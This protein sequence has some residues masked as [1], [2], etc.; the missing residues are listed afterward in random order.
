MLLIPK[1]IGP[2]ATITII[3]RSPTFQRRPHHR[4]R[5]HPQ[6]HAPEWDNQTV[7]KRSS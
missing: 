2:P 6:C 7:G 1:D 4:H 5:G 3:F